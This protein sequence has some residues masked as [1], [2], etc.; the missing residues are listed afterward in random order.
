MEALMEQ[1]ISF[2]CDTHADADDCRNC[3]VRHISLCS[4]VEK[5]DLD[6]LQ[7]MSSKA[8]F[9]KD[10]LLFEQETRIERVFVVLEGMVRLYRL[11]PD[12]QRQITGFLGPGDVLGGIK[13]QA[14]AHCTAQAITDVRVCAF[15]R[16]DFLDFLHDQQ[17]ETE[18]RVI[19]QEVEEVCAFKRADFLDF[20][21][22]HADL[23]FRLLITAT[24]E[25]EA[26]QEHITLLGRRRVGERLAAFLLVSNHRWPLNGGVNPAVSLP[27]TRADIADHLGQTVES[28]SRAFKQLKTLGYIDLP[29]PNL[30]ILKNVPALYGLAGFDEMPSQHIALGL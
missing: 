1:P 28:V 15:K 18:V 9:L 12:G 26:Q 23:C 11:L 6:Q 14:G 10:S 13:R 21:H 22:D 27:M 8:L 25:I 7:S 30:V 20:L 5:N 4:H 17:P 29:K 2:C 16:A 3:V 19:V 24:D